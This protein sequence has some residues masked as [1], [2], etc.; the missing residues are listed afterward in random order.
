MLLNTPEYRSRRAAPRARR[1]ASTASSILSVL[2]GW[3][4]RATRPQRLPSPRIRRR[5]RT[6]SAPRRKRRT[7]R[8]LER[9]VVRSTTRATA[10]ATRR[11]GCGM[12]KPS[13]KSLMPRFKRPAYGHG[14]V[15]P[16]TTAPR[17]AA[18]GM[19]GNDYARARRGRGLAPAI[20]GAWPR[21][22]CDAGWRRTGAAL[23]SCTDH[24]VAP[25]S[26]ASA[27][28]TCWSNA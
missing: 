8:H 26:T 28:R 4:A 24:R 2:D 22:G 6:T 25:R 1:P 9:Q 17:A 19:S 20:D 13:M 5:P 21:Y 14:L 15:T 18:A 10:T 23:G 7:A 3:W 16:V 27:P 12:S 11:A